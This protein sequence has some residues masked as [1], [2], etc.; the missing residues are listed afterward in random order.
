MN[1]FPPQLSC[2]P[3]AVV[4]RRIT[5]PQKNSER[6]SYLCERYCRECDLDTEQV[7]VNDRDQGREQDIEQQREPNTL[8]NRASQ[9]EE[10]TKPRWPLTNDHCLESR[11]N[12]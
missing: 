12:P 9:H 1:D 8:Q 6:Q 2:L 10:Q 5:E 11:G 3:I 4:G 7:A